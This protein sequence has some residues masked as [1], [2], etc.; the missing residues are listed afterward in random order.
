MHENVCI[1]R[2]AMLKDVAIIIKIRKFRQCQSEKGFIVGSPKCTFAQSLL[3]IIKIFT[4][5][6]KITRSFI[7]KVFL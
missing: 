2:I 4:T 7:R 5:L 6:L 1:Y 3:F